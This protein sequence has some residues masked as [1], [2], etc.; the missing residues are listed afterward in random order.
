MSNT[1]F[2]RAAAVGMG[3]GLNPSLVFTRGLATM[4]KA[5]KAIK[6]R[7]RIELGGQP[8]MVSKITQGKRGKGGGFV[9]ASLKNLVSGSTTEKTF[10]SDE[11]VTYAQMAKQMVNYSWKDGTT[12][13]FLDSETYEE[14]RVDGTLLDNSQY[15]VEGTDV[16]LF[17]FKGEVIGVDLPT[18][19]EFEVMS[20][21][22]VKSAG[23]N[24]PA[25][26]SSGARVLVPDFIKVGETIRV[27]IE[28]GK[29]VERA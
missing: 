25:T 6:P 16:K 21:E 19:C 5:S 9:K 18:I 1:I 29:Y 20:I 23:G 12:L 26:L 2:R 14:V 10:T 13:V 8:W 27:N 11:M 15:L 28:E 3:L 22:L 17:L 24:Y 4:E 7:S